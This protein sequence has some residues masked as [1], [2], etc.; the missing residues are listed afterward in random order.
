MKLFV[1]LAV[2]L[3]TSISFA[4]KAP[5]ADPRFAPFAEEYVKVGGGHAFYDPK[6]FPLFLKTVNSFNGKN[7]H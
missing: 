3:I 7:F 5:N 2:L 4:A 6:T 1:I